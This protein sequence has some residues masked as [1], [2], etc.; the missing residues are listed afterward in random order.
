MPAVEAGPVAVAGACRCPAGR[1]SRH[2]RRHPSRSCAAPG[3]RRGSGSRPAGRGSARAREAGAGRTRAPSACALAARWPRPGRQGRPRLETRRELD[4]VVRQQ[5]VDR[6]RVRARTADLVGVGVGDCFPAPPRRTGTGRR[7]VALVD[8]HRSSAHEERAPVELEARAAVEPHERSR[9]Q[10][11]RLSGPREIAVPIDPIAR[12]VV[13]A[14]QPDAGYAELEQRLLHRMKEVHGGASR[15]PADVTHQH[16]QLRAGI[17]CAL[18]RGQHGAG[19][20]VRIADEPD[21]H[22]GTVVT[23]RPVAEAGFRHRAAKRGCAKRR[24]AKRR[25]AQPGRHKP[26]ARSV[27]PRRC[28]RG[29]PRSSPILGGTATGASARSSWGTVGASAGGPPARPWPRR[30]APAS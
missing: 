24:C 7:A 15:P 28:P 12:K 22:R 2:R 14:V 20:A 11:R 8:R 30:V 3:R 21:E 1:G 16:D 10:T 17:A 6:P 26:P 29:R 19:L 18:Q 9:R 23:G 5:H 13:I 27:S 25:C 4:A